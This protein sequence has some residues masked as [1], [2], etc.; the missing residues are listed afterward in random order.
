MLIQNSSRFV[1]EASTITK[2]SFA[3]VNCFF[4]YY[5]LE[6]KLLTLSTKSQKTCET[7]YYKPTLDEMT[8]TIL[9]DRVYPFHQKHAKSSTSNVKEYEQPLI[10]SARV[11]GTTD[12]KRDQQATK[13]NQNS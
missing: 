11:T 3:N 7:H 4:N 9:V 10:G 2:R 8:Q 6:K 13:N 5:K 12:V 1:F